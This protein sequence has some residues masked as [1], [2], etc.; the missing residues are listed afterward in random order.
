VFDAE[1][2]WFHL[3]VLIHGLLKTS[4]QLSTRIER[5]DS[6]SNMLLIIYQVPL[7]YC[8]TNRRCRVV[9]TPK[10]TN[11]GA[12][13]MLNLGY[14]HESLP[15]SGANILDTIHLSAQVTQESIIS[16]FNTN[17]RAI[18]Y[19]DGSTT[20]LSYVPRAQNARTRK[21]ASHRQPLCHRAE[22]IRGKF[23][24]LAQRGVRNA[25]ST[26]VRSLKSASHSGL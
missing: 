24:A 13:N 14:G 16:S 17:G 25:Q 3:S 19:L 22:D 18:R 10:R 15:I 4:N 6:R 7:P 26:R 23:G 1:N 5:A 20:F 21:D 11:S 8:T 2:W 12:I 9:C